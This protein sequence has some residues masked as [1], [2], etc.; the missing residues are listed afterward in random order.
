MASS[1]FYQT[2]LECLRQ[3]DALSA[4]GYSSVC[5]VTTVGSDILCLL[6]A[7]QNVGCTVKGAQCDWSTEKKRLILPQVQEGFTEEGA[8][9][10]AE[11]AW[12]I[13]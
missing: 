4:L 5:D 7:A 3:T 13:T 11:K 2:E 1:I 8:F 10:L 12:I 6:Y 9:G